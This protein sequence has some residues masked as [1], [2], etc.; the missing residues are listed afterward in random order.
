[1]CI[2]DRKWIFPQ[3]VDQKRERVQNKERVVNTIGEKPEMSTRKSAFESVDHMTVLAILQSQ[4]LKPC[5]QQREEALENFDYEQRQ[6]YYLPF[7]RKL[8]LNRTYLVSDMYT[9]EAN[10]T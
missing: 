5:H 10:F 3:T 4:R 9:D 6:T 8:L 1:M 2:R 7:Y